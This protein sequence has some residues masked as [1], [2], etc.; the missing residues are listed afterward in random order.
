LTALSVDNSIVAGMMVDVV[1]ETSTT[2]SLTTRSRRRIVQIPQVHDASLAAEV[3][4]GVIARITKEI[5]TSHDL[6][7]MIAMAGDTGAETDTTR[8]G[9]R[10][11]RLLLLCIA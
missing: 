11:M 7:A 5:A 3:R 8:E 2:T 6:V 9:D 10:R 4:H 1:E